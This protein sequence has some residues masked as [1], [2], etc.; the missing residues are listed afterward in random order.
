MQTIGTVDVNAAGRPEHDSVP[1][2]FSNETVRGGVIRR[3]GFGLHDHPTHTINVELEANEFGG[4]L[5]RCT[6]PES[7]EIVRHQRNNSMSEVM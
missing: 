5:L 3:I 4:D 1:R 2:R 6:I 7:D